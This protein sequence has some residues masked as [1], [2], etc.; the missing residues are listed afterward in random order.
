ME[1]DQGKTITNTTF[2]RTGSVGVVS[3]H[4]TT[5]GLRVIINNMNAAIFLFYK[6]VNINQE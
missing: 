5:S 2:Q 6:Q 3:D 4:M 1:L